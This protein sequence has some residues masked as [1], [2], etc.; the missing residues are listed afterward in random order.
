[1]VT[2]V[3]SAICMRLPSRNWDRQ[4]TPGAVLW[5][6]L[7][8][9]EAAR[10][11]RASSALVSLLAGDPRPGARLGL[12]ALLTQEQNQH[13][14][15]GQIAARHDKRANDVARP[16][17]GQTRRGGHGQRGD[18]GEVA[19]QDGRRAMLECCQSL[20]MAT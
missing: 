14:K 12:G 9:S 15:A 6:A 4:H 19:G 20:A 5:R 18:V 3:L 17:E 16:L 10:L 13:T 7:L 11:R 1:M 8:A 2:T